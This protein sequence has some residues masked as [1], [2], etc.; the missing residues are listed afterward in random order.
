[1]ST[2]TKI[3]VVVLVA[4]VLFAS[5][6]FIQQAVTGPDWKQA[7]EEQEQR[8]KVAEVSD[9]NNMQNTQVY[10]RL[11]EDAQRNT[12]TTAQEYLDKLAAKNVEISRLTSQLADRTGEV[13]KLSAF[14]EAFE[15]DLKAQIALN[16][17]VLSQL[18]AMRTDNGKL[19]DQ[20]RQAQH[21]IKEEQTN[22]EILTKSRKSLQ[23]QIV[24]KNAI[25]ADLNDQLASGGAKVGPAKPVVVKWAKIDATVDAVR[26]GL[27]S[28]NV[29]SASG[30]RMGMEF[31]IYRGEDFVAHLRIADVGV[32][33][34]TGIILEDRKR[35]PKV[36]DKASTNLE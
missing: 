25:I 7:F 24:Q 3:C 1:M 12:D 35:E 36:G 20:L 28:L 9:R 8:A 15:I 29:G 32:A 33:N 21:T 13:R 16:K 10:R 14:T 5:G 11:Y 23:E 17:G 2:L 34:S 18:E 6:P 27:A 26:D 19:S 30:V 4:L 22:R 31:I